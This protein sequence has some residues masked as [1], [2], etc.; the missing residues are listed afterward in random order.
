M[1]PISVSLQQID[2]FL[3]LQWNLVYCTGPGQQMV[4]E[5]QGKLKYLEE[6]G[7]SVT[8]STSP[9]RDLTRARTGTRA[10]WKRRHG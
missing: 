3:S 7:P 4:L 8:L 10:V 6:P 1:K 9:T 5:W 2:Q